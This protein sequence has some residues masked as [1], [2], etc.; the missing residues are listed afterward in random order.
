MDGARSDWLQY[1]DQPK[2]LED[3]RWWRANMNFDA[4]AHLRRIQTPVLAIWGGADFITP[5]TE[6]HEK[7]VATLKAAGNADV[8]TR[9][10]ENA[11]HRIE[12]GFGEGAEGNWHWFGIA[13]GA[14]DMTGEWLERVLQKKPLISPGNAG[15]SAVRG[16][17]NRD[18]SRQTSFEGEVPHK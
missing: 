13:P 7:L 5:W 1:V 3:L 8:T 2:S 10:F 14:L 16:H 17:S 15:S 4:I 11:D 12:I 9:I 18:T 6:Y